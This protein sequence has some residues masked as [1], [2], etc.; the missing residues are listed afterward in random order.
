MHSVFAMCECTQHNCTWCDV[1]FAAVYHNIADMGFHNFSNTAPTNAKQAVE[2]A[3]EISLP[4]TID[5][6]PEDFEVVYVFWH[7]DWIYK[8]SDVV[9]LVRPSEADQLL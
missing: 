3:I 7:L 4:P 5:D 1:G 8:K 6:S 2:S 9:R